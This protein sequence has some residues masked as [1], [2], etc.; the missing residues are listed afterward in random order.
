MASLK[1]SF[2]IAVTVVAARAAR[3]SCMA[4]LALWIAAPAPSHAQQLPDTIAQRVAACIACHG[5]EGRASS[6]GYYPRIA[7]KPEG[8]LNNQL[9]NFRDGHRQ[10]P[11]M[12][13]LLDH[14]WGANLH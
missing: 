13:Y 7:G 3:F 12:T 2:V 4:L 9:T 8:Y 11:L 10:Y 6:D 5:K 14:L 1:L